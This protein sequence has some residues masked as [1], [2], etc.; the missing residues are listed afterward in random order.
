MAVPHPAYA[1]LRSRGE[2]YAACAAEVGVTAGSLRQ[3]LVGRT[4]SWPRLRRALAEHWNLP[5]SV[6]FYDEDAR[7]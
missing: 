2:T 6:L 4:R 7:V 3:V 5:E 1:V